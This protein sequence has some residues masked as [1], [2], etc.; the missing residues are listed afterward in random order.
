MF[1]MSL[2][3]Q[4][5]H[6][7]EWNRHIDIFSICLLYCNWNHSHWFLIFFHGITW[8]GWHM[9][10]QHFSPRLFLAVFVK[11]FHWTWNSCFWRWIQGFPCRN[12]LWYDFIAHEE[13][14]LT[15]SYGLYCLFIWDIAI[16]VHK[17]PWYHMSILVHLVGKLIQTI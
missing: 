6:S 15:S 13:T 10:V 8:L 7:K 16:Y 14:F 4:D 9:L 5:F 17:T 3:Y 11:V 12:F 1:G 2:V